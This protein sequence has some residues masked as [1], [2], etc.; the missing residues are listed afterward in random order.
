MLKSR[1]HLQAYVLIIILKPEI[2]SNIFCY[3]FISAP[4]P[5]EML[6]IFHRSF[7]LSS[8]THDCACIIDQQ[9]SHGS[10]WSPNRKPELVLFRSVNIG[11]KVKRWGVLN[12]QT[13]F[14]GSPADGSSTPE[15]RISLPAV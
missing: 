4:C 9:I 7:L 6:E 3:S 2:I 15:A 13:L 12:L 10:S 1:M 5:C 14:C 8:L 11:L